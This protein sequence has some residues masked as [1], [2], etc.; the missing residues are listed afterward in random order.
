MPSPQPRRPGHRRGAAHPRARLSDDQVR[1]MRQTYESWKHSGDRR[2]YLALSRLYGCS[3][4]TARDIITY[5]TRW[6]V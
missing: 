3:A 5:R 2:G 4:S 6:D 1:E